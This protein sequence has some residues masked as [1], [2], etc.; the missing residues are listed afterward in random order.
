MKQKAF[1]GE[2]NTLFSVPSN[3]VISLYG[4][5]EEVFLRKKKKLV[6]IHV[7]LL[8]LWSMLHL[9]GRRIDEKCLISLSLCGNPENKFGPHTAPRHISHI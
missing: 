6:N 4:N 7:L 2:G 5:G 9:F 3:A 8:T 1:C